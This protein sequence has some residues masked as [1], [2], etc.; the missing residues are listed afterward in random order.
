MEWS[1]VHLIGCFGRSLLEQI[2]VVE[3]I[4]EDFALV[5]VTN[6]VRSQ[7]YSNVLSA[8]PPESVSKVF[9]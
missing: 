1:T 9:P 6:R 3:I 2:L 7:T 4:L 8:I 5:L